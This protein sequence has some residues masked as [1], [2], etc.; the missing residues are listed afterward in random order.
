MTKLLERAIEATRHLS[1]DLQDEVA[2]LMLHF[3]GDTPLDLTPEE[4]A[5]LDE[6]EAAA[7]RGEFAAGDEIRA[8]WAKHGL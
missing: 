5:A 3:T 6:S 1:E 2:R 4:N 7:A 8:I